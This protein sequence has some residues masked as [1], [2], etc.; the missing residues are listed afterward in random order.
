M[1]AT[2]TFSNSQCCFH[3]VNRA[4][5]QLMQIQIVRE[6]LLR[7]LSQVINS[8]ERRVTTPILGN[9]M[10]RMSNGV[11][12]ITGTDLEVETVSSIPAKGEDGS[13]TVPARKFYDIVR[14]LSEGASIKIICGN[15]G[16]ATMQ[17]GR[18]RFQ[19]M[20]LPADQF[21]SFDEVEVA[22][23]LTVQAG[24]LRKLFD[25]T[26][27]AMGNNDVRHYLNGMLLD[28]REQTVRGVTTDGHRLACFEVDH[29]GV[30]APVKAIIPR[31]GV[32]EISRLIKDVG[33]E[34]LVTLEFG[35]H[36][37]RLR[38]GQAAFST[39]LISGP[40]PDYEA[41]IPNN[42]PHKITVETGELHGAIGRAFILAHQEKQGV[43]LRVS[44]NSMAI[45][46]SNR[47]N[48]EALEQ[49][50]C[51]STLES[52]FV[53]FNGNYM[54][55]AIMAIEGEHIELQV[56]DGNSSLLV[57]DKSNPRYRQVIM[58]MRS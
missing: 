36:S 15:D 5:G 33:D 16:K 40:Y 50:A 26:T 47:E 7:P 38:H 1:G 49:V 18:S 34:E 17:A 46:S 4:T 54:L 9:L 30:Q 23:S 43:S 22:T 48:E 44:P 12:S 14:S 19:L 32:T 42:P 10:L 52:M 24:P 2:A 29:N 3:V 35:M 55:Q 58:P 8:V 25:R 27:F 56:R 45:S 6:A 31:K 53:S 11:L 13:T 39:K 57:L 28:V 21:P 41:V 51:T 37:V 20:T